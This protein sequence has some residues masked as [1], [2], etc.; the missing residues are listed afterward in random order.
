MRTVIASMIVSLVA[1]S[2]AP[3]ASAQVAAASI[4]QEV[5]SP[6]T[7]QTYMSGGSYSFSSC[8]LAEPGDEF[9]GTGKST[10]SLIGGVSYLK[11]SATT[12]GFDYSR[13]PTYPGNESY[14]DLAQGISFLTYSFQVAAPVGESVPLI[15]S[16]S[17][18][19][20][21]SGSLAYGTW[22]SLTV[23]VLSEAGV[24]GLSDT[25]T[26]VG[27]ASYCGPGTFY[28]DQT[29]VTTNLAFT[30]TSSDSF[31]VELVAG[32]EAGVGSASGGSFTATIDPAITFAPG[33][34]ST[35]VT[36]EFSPDIGSPVSSVPEPSNGELLLAG[37]VAT[38]YYQYIRRKLRMEGHCEPRSTPQI[39]RRE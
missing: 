13:P 15:F 18:T 17:Q 10:A 30:A 8:F 29:S 39:G 33:F 19:S 25:S 4:T 24:G 12:S 20:T 2:L 38:L 6:L 21:G 5:A 34:D 7:G 32:T 16:A 26:C 28:G 22:N 31:Q 14:A 11:E 27:D 36:L 37:L 35:G 1:L 9:C 23:V 3:P